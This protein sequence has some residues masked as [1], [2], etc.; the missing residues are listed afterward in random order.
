MRHNPDRHRLPPF[1][2]NGVLLVDKPA[3]WT[4][5]DVVS[6]MRARFNAVKV[7][8]C[9]TLDPAATG[10]LVVVFGKFTKLSQKF[11]G[12]DKTYT[13]T[14]LLGT[15]TD[16]QDMD[17]E[18]VRT[19]DWSGVN[20]A[21]LIDAFRSFEGDILQTPPMVSAVKKDGE[22][23]YKL[24]RQGIEVEREA[25]EITIHHA[26]ITNARLPYADFEVKCSKGT[27]IRTLCSDVGK[28][29]GCGAVLYRLN[30]IHSGDF[31]LVDA[32]SMEDIKT[33]TQEDLSTKLDDFLFNRLSHMQRFNSF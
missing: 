11:S 15:E 9:G 28:K 8:H 20:E 23:L 10:L 7:G 19:A 3:G 18:V 5:H 26:K 14:I 4:S 16:S 29:L 17:G 12:E 22:R 2:K 32:H 27:Y 13:G 21:M 24:A 25:K 6:F 1:Q 31:S 33:W 30:R